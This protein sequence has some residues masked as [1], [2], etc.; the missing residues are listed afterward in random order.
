MKLKDMKV[1]YKKN[2]EKLIWED[3]LREK[4]RQENVAFEPFSSF[5]DKNSLEKS[6]LKE[7]NFLK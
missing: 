6:T 1:Y 7:F 4:C 3:M 5:N 2:E